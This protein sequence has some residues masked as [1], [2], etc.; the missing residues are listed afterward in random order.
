MTLLETVKQEK[1]IVIVRGVQGENLL[2]LAKALY[3]GGIRL[4]EITYDAKG[5]TPDAVTAE[6]IK[7]LKEAFEGKMYIGAGT[8]LNERQ[9]AL[10]KAAGGSFIISPN[11]STAVI[12][13]TKAAGLLSM[14]GALTP[15][16]IVHAYDAG[17]DFVKVFPAT[18]LG[19]AYIKAVAAPLSHIPLLAV[20]GVNDKNIGE[21]L[22]AGACG[23]GVGG[24]LV[25]KTAIN[26]GRFADITAAART[27]VKAVKDAV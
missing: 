23:F 25:D 19:A 5:E 18:G 27:Y 7:M 12:K 15:T 1:L 4:M 3:D 10:T 13:A 26:E 2:A 20:G 24:C 6:N 21:F 8:V 9:V 11:V 16:E 17:A 22:H 14:P